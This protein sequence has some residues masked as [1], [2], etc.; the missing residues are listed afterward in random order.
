M[1]SGHLYQDIL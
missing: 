1:T